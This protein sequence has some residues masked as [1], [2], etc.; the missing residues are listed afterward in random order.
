ME[1]EGRKE[2]EKNTKEE[3]GDKLS[4]HDI[5]GIQHHSTL[6]LKSIVIELMNSIALLREKY[7]F[8][9]WEKSSACRKQRLSHL[10]TIDMATARNTGTAGCFYS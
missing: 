9:T 10:G 7:C 4:K 6:D 5:N 8:G 3:K 2:Q 1:K